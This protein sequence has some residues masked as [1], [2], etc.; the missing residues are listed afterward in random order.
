[1]TLFWFILFFNL[2]LDSIIETLALRIMPTG[3][4]FRQ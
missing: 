2:I 4:T 3:S 1:V